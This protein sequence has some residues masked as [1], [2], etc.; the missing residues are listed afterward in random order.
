MFDELERLKEGAWDL[1]KQLLRMSKLS[2]E[3]VQTLVIGILSAISRSLFF[4]LPEISPC[5][6]SSIFWGAAAAAVWQR[7]RQWADISS[8]FVGTVLST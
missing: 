2:L 3:V 7:Q 5:L 6:F 4:V 1:P 8:V